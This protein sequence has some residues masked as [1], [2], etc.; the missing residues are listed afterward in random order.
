MQQHLSDTSTLRAGR[1]AWVV[2]AVQSF[3]KRYGAASQ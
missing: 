3:L 1:V 2:S